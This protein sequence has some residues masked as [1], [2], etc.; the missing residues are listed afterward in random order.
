MN[1]KPKIA[2]VGC[3][4]ISDIYLTNL[5]GCFSKIVEVSSVS[6]I[7]RER[8]VAA[9]KKYNISTVA[10][11][12]EVFST[13][14]DILLNLTTPPYHTS[15]AMKALENGK[16]VYNEKPFALTRDE[17]QKVLERADKKG[18]LTGNAPDTFYGA[19]L[20]TCRKII[21]DGHIGTIISA[22][23]AMACPGHESWHPGPD[24]Y[25]KPGGG[26]MLDMGP[27]YLTALVHLMGPMKAVTGRAATGHKERVCTAESTYGHKIKVETETHFT[28]FIDFEN[29]AV[30]NVI[31]SFDV[32]GH[33]MPCLEIHGTKGSLRCPD[34][35]TFTGPVYLKTAGEKEWKEIPISDFAYE[36]NSRGAGVADMALA[37][38][39]KGKLRAC[40]ELAYHVLDAMLAF[41]D[42]SEQNMQVKL[43][44]TTQ[45]PQPLTA[46]LQ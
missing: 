36:Q 26:P 21:D 12:T 32:T 34:P 2:V 4:N 31:M 24:F 1:R 18:L 10:D 11:P 8:A 33:T 29:G 15:I 46:K 37:I 14:A 39:G 44:S 20:Q 16:H 9:A 23:A 38:G 19:G 43:E 30:A 22:T 27:Y 42:S 13:D 17:G 7:L 3:G 5:T 25:Y 6:D 35:N 45:K 41:Y 40:G 28:G